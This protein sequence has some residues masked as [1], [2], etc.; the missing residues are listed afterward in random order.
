MCYEVNL[1][2]KRTQTQEQKTITIQVE[3][4]LEIGEDEFVFLSKK[5]KTF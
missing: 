4:N 1:Q 2:A 5:L 3:G